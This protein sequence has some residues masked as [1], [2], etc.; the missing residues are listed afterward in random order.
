MWKMDFRRGS[1]SQVLWRQLLRGPRPPSVQWP[2]SR[3]NV[4]AV[5]HQVPEVKKGK[6]KG[7]GQAKAVGKG[8]Q[9][10]APRHNAA[11]QSSSVGAPKQRVPMSPDQVL[12][13]ARSRVAKLKQVPATLGEEDHM[14]PAVQEALAKAEHQAREQPVCER[15]RSTKRFVERKQKRVEAKEATKRAREALHSA[16]AFHREEENLLAEEERRLEELMIEEKAIPSPFQVTPVCNVNAELD[17]LRAEIARLRQ[18]RDRIRPVVVPSVEANHIPVK[19]QELA[20]WMNHR[21]GDLRVAI[22]ENNAAKRLQLITLLAEGR[23]RLHSLEEQDALLEEDFAQRRLARVGSP[24]TEG[25][26]SR[27]VSVR[28]E[29]HSSWRSFSPGSH[30][31]SHEK[32]HI[33]GRGARQPVG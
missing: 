9:Q 13:A 17:Q 7:S 5:D 26:S 3:R 4:S 29:E 11:G 31:R 14:Y 15:I 24:R 32:G 25:G 33:I 20:S 22:E 12:E 2:Q 8:C 18:Q 1:L 10:K 23:R 16:V 19:R 27:G 30:D 21:A 28:F 6:G